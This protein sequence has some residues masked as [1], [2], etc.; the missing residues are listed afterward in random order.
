[1]ITDLKDTD[2]NI[3]SESISKMKYIETLNLDFHR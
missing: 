1:M 2:L 3:L